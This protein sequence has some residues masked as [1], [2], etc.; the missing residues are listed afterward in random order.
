MR[1]VLAAYQAPPTPNPW[2]HMDLAWHQLWP[3]RQKQKVLGLQEP[4]PFN[5]A[6]APFLCKLPRH[7]L[8]HCE[9]ELTC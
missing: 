1:W 5:Q 4:L 2:L 8:G 9:H 6:C 3:M 7:T